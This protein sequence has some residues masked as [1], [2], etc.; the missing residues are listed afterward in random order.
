MLYYQPKIDLNTSEIIGCE[1]LIRW[2]H[3]SGNVIYPDRFISIAEGK[4]LIEMLR[5]EEMKIDRQDIAIQ[6]LINEINDE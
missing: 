4:A 5:W 6:E 2:N 1:A 3:F